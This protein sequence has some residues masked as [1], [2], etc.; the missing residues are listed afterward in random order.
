MPQVVVITGMHR[1]GTSLVASL[2][3]RAGV[4][5]G[6]RLYGPDASNPRGYF[7]DA[8]FVE[9]HNRLLSDRGKTFLVE[10]SF[11][12]EPSRAEEE[13]ADR[14]VGA[15][16]REP[17]WGWKD[18]RTSLF[19]EFWD[20]RLE[21]TTYLFVFR[22]PL[23]VL[24]S[25]L[26]RDDYEAIGLNEAIRA[27]EVY[28]E[29]ILEFRE[30]RPERSVLVDVHGVLGSLDSLNDVLDKKLGLDITV[31]PEILAELY[32]ASEL[33]GSGAWARESFG[34][35]EPNAVK[36]YER[37]LGAA[38]VVA[39]HG[40]ESP[41]HRELATFRVLA[42]ELLPQLGPARRGLLLTLIELVSPEAVETVF[43]ET[44]SLI[45]LQHERIRDLEQTNAE[46]ER[47][48]AW[49][50]SRSVRGIARDRIVAR[51]SGRRTE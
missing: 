30:R 51:L 3:Q 2:I 29:R 28:N 19:L 8:D 26:R 24:L 33:H 12:F 31:T 45:R 48:N 32:H 9:F 35:L 6:Q 44:R 16:S 25:L 14:L 40:S 13:Q 4:D 11:S 39:A 22:H 7:E 43:D 17:L 37:L 20:A 10:E 5:V 49:L 21:G 47:T 27:W 36:L 34:L 38:D 23:D 46:L 50:E 1:S 42:G 15:R 18:P 41:E